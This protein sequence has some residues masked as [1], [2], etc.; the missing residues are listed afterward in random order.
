M[1]CGASTHAVAGML[2][3]RTGVGG[4]SA[5]WMGVSSS[6]RWSYLSAGPVTS[7]APVGPL[8]EVRSL[9]ADRRVV[10][11]ARQH[12]RVGRDLG[13]EPFVEGLDDRGEVAA[14]EGRVARSARE[15]RVAAE[16]HR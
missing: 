2:R 7:P 10:A 9:V 12:D 6:G 5:V 8:L 15:Q 11:V 16:Q 4:R 3:S 14:L 13:E 1:D